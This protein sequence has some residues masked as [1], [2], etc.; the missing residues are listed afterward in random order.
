MCLTVNQEKSDRSRPYT[1]MK[2]LQFRISGNYKEYGKLFK[3]QYRYG[4][5]FLP[6]FSWKPVRFWVI[7]D[8]RAKGMFMDLT[9][10]TLEEA[11]EFA[12]ECKEDPKTFLDLLKEE[13]RKS[14]EFVP[15]TFKIKI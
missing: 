5:Y 11:I 4:R 2:K 12:D 13:E 7:V 6:L 8:N 15:R 3:I 1:Q 14:W 9:F 10:S